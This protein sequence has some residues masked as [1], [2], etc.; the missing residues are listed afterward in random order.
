MKCNRLLYICACAW[1]SIDQTATK[2][3]FSFVPGRLTSTLDFYSITLSSSSFPNSY[4]YIYAYL[5][6]NEIV[7]KRF[8]SFLIRI[9]NCAHLSV[10]D[11]IRCDA[12]KSK[13]SIT[14]MM[15]SWT[16]FCRSYGIYHYYFTI[17]IIYNLSSYHCVIIIIS[18]MDGSARRLWKHLPAAQALTELTSLLI[19]IESCYWFVSILSS[20]SV[21][22]RTCIDSS[23]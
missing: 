17:I 10:S 3:I 20:S 23:R 5:E 2:L 12:I 8:G 4:T 7:V 14:W 6:R 9:F 22:C 1:T 19:F 13:S 16:A 18:K 21:S 11:V 15:L